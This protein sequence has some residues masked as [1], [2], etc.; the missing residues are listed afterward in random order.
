MSV[1]MNRDM[2][3]IMLSI[4]G[5]LLLS[6]DI[7]LILVLFKESIPVLTY[8]GLRIF[9]EFQWNAAEDPAKEVYGIIPPLVGSLYVAIL[10]IM[11]ASFFSIS[12]TVFIQEIIPYRARLAIEELINVAASF[13]TV[14]YGLWGLTLIVP[15]VRQL[16]VKLGYVNVTGASIVT[17]G[18]VLSTMIA[19][20]STAII[21]SVY[22]S[23]PLSYIEAIAS[24]GAT[25]IERAIIVLK[26]I[27]PA[28]VSSLLLGFGRAVGETTAV[29]LVIGNAYRLPLDPFLPA[30]TATSLIANNFGM[31]TYYKY[32]YSALMFAALVLLITSSFFSYIGLRL[33]NRSVRIVRG[34]Q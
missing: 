11:F 16:A 10:A 23:V 4:P 27:F 15:L 17:A 20:Y 2:L 24:L 7:L 9:T 6:I 12:L 25:K 30:S 29:T 19:P 34:E 33:A 21:K 14:L 18:L 1:S 32:E 8:E 22:A 5:V 26:M 28:I 31:A 3:R 13:P